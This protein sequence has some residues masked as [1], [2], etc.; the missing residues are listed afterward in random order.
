MLALLALVLVAGM[1]VWLIRDLARSLRMPH[2]PTPP[3]ED[4]DP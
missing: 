1:V 4:K 2:W 3:R